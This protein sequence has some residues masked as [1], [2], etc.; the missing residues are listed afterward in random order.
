[1]GSSPAG[2]AIYT[3]MCDHL[4][5]TNETYFQ[6]MRVALTLSAYALTTGVVFLI[7]ALLPCTFK[8]TGSGLLKRIQEIVDTRK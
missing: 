5:T 6:H 8:T 1:V 2:P 4:K 3:Q 7:H